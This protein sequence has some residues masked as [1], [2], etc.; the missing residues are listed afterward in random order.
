MLNGDNHLV[1]VKAPG[2]SREQESVIPQ[3]NVA[4]I[5]GHQDILTGLKDSTLEDGGVLLG[6][7]RH[8]CAADYQRKVS[9]WGPPGGFV[10]IVSIIRRSE[11]RGYKKRLD[12]KYL[13][14]ITLVTRLEPY[15]HCRMAQQATFWWGGFGD[16]LLTLP[17]VIRICGAGLLNLL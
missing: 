12:I 6:W 15:A 16:R 1:A 10:P 7:I 17:S 5:F 9:C 4:G 2:G 14:C 8:W 3:I 13:E 11:A